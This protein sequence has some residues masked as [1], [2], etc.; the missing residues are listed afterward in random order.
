MA[1]L[2]IGGYHV[3]SVVD[4][5]RPFLEARKFF[6]DLT[7]EM[8]AQGRAE[9]P[10]GQITA[11]GRLQMSFQSFVVKTGRHTILIDTCCGNDK[12]RPGRPEF[13]HLKT[14]YIATLASAGVKPEQVD[15]V[16]CTHLHW[17]HVG[18][19]PVWRMAS[20]F[21]P[22]RMPDILSRARSS[23]IGTGASAK[24]RRGFTSHR[25][26]TVFCP[27]CGQKERCWW[28]AITSWTAAFGSSHARDIRRVMS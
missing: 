22:S 4:I 12:E 21:R 13:G 5:E 23:N 24:G 16:M 18:W 20:G 25:S 14:D 3:D 17:D 26:R 6:P 7:D 28:I 8:L 1:G 10:P 11:D 2:R 9:L 15:F 27:S 19:T